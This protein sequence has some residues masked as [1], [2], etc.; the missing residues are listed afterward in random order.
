MLRY[1][2]EAKMAGYK[3]KSAERSGD[4]GQAFRRR[5]RP[6]LP[7]PPGSAKIARVT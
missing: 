1:G 4:Y 7:N 6:F 2:I 3:E 5:S